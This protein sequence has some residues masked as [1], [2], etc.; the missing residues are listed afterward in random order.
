MARPWFYRGMFVRFG[1][2]AG[3]MTDSFQSPS[4]WLIRC[5]FGL[6]A[7]GLTTAAIGLAIGGSQ[8]AILG[9][10]S[11]AS[12]AAITAASVAAILAG[13]ISIAPSATIERL[14]A[15]WKIIQSANSTIG[16]ATTFYSLVVVALAVQ[17]LLLSKLLVANQNAVDDQADYLRVAAEVV[18]MGGPAALP[19]NLWKGTF[20]EANRHP[21]SV[22][23]LSLRPDF[24]TGKLLSAAFAICLTLATAIVG[25]QLYGPLVGALAAAMIAINFAIL[26]SGSLVACETLLALFVL[27]AWRRAVAM[28]VRDS[29]SLIDSL[30]SGLLFGAAFLTKGTALMLFAIVAGFVASVRWK[31]AILMTVGFVLIASP[32]LV[33]NLR[34]YSDPAYS[35]NTRFLFADSFEAGL[36]QSDLGTMANGRRYFATHRGS[37]IARRLFRG[38]ATEAFV[39]ARSLGPAP[40]GSGRAIIGAV[41][42]LLALAEWS[43]DRAGSMS[44]ACLAFLWIF[45]AWYAPIATSDRFVVPW[46][47]PIAIA[48]SAHLVRIG[49]VT[50]GDNRTITIL[51][52]GTAVLILLFGVWTMTIDCQRFFQ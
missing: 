13:W 37:D 47:A 1:Q 27:L 51:T 31:Q 42:L 26:H 4:R 33:R 14:L 40:L 36:Q 49:A 45:F 50:T 44:I 17:I 34:V 5:V 24:S 12:L 48:A 46:I 41:F 19:G 43:A 10:Q 25:R 18:A 8:R 21:F 39:I 52:A 2:A 32:L 15:Q 7:I 30:G 28:I 29:T 23:L 11:L 20:V 3:D 35:Y 16:S 22:I 6:L 9:N 38:L